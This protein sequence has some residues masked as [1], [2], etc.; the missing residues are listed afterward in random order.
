MIHPIIGEEKVTLHAGEAAEV[1]VNC[2]AFLIKN[3]SA[4][5]TV[6]FREAQ[7]GVAASTETGFALAAGE[8]CHVPLC[9]RTLSLAASADAD[10]RLLYIG[11]GY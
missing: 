10:V 2:R 7:D 6:Y 1:A 3:N 8:S 9:A 11:E 4:N 5:A